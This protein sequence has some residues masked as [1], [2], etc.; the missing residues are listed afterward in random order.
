[1]AVFTITHVARGSSWFAGEICCPDEANHPRADTFYH[2]LQLGELRRKEPPVLNTDRRVVTFIHTTWDRFSQAETLAD[3]YSDADHFVDRVFYAL[4]QSGVHS[5]RVWEAEHTGDGAQLRIVCE[6]GTVI[7][8]TLPRDEH[9]I[10]LAISS[11]HEAVQISV[12]AIL[13]AI[14]QRGGPAMLDLPLEQ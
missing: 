3:L 7:A 4:E 6:D 13:E 1:M 5:E 12:A 8:S 10:P 2:K 9:T 14:R 11:S